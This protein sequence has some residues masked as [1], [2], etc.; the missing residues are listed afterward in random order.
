M[1]PSATSDAPSTERGTVDAAPKF[2]PPSSNGVLDIIPGDVSRRTDTLGRTLTGLSAGRHRIVETRRNGSIRGGSYKQ[3]MELLVTAPFGCRIPVCI[4]H[5]DLGQIMMIYLYFS[6][7]SCA[8]LPILNLSNRSLF[9]V[10]LGPAAAARASNGLEGHSSITELLHSTCIRVL[11]NLYKHSGEDS[12]YFTTKM[13]RRCL[14]LPRTNRH[15]NT[16]RRTLFLALAPRHILCCQLEVVQRHGQRMLGIDIELIPDGGML[17]RIRRR[18]G[19]NN[20][21]RGFCLH[22]V[23]D[24]VGVK[25]CGCGGR[26]RRLERG[27]ERRKQTR[28]DGVLDDLRDRRRRIVVRFSIRRRRRRI[29][30]NRRQ[31][32]GD[33]HGRLVMRMY[34]GAAADR[35]SQ[36]FGS[37]VHRYTL[38][39]KARVTRHSAPQLHSIRIEIV[40]CEAVVGGPV[41]ERVGQVGAVARGSEGDDGCS[42]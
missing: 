23:H 29:A 2:V 41:T 39:R 18:L 8:I 6:V 25:A 5:P 22:N 7:I 3:D 36:E 31:G 32:L 4:L 30:A 16:P 20:A 34:D 24:L 42:R 10:A 13:N 15:S 11:Q 27:E 19:R 26:R 12:D 17:F 33:A 14:L 1:F 40:P 38:S 37:H 35:L 28:G 21:K 9:E